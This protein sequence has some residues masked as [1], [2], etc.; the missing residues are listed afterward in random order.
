LPLRL[1]FPVD[2]QLSPVVDFTGRAFEFSLPVLTGCCISGSAL[3][4]TFG[5]RL[6]PTF[7]LRLRTQPPTN[8]VVIS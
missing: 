4:L 3:R 7:L 5:F 8:C 1:G 2:P 6:G